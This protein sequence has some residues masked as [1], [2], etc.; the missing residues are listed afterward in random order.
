MNFLKFL[1]PFFFSATA[2][3]QAGVSASYIRMT[4][5]SLPSTCRAGDIRVDTSYIIQ[6]CGNTNNW[7]PTF[8]L[9]SQTANTVLAGPTSGGSATPT[10]RALV[11]ADLPSSIPD[12]KL[13]TISTA[14]K[15]AN[16]ATT[17]TSSNTPSTIVLRDGSGNFAAGT[18]TADLNGNAT[19]STSTTTI[20][21]TDDTST[22]ATMF[23]TWVTA[24]TG[25]LPNKVS[26]TKLTF[27]PSIPSVGI[28]VAP[29]TDVLL[30]MDASTTSATQRIVFSGHGVNN[31][32]IRFKDSRG[33]VGSPTATQTDDILGFISGMPYGT[34]GYTAASTIAFNMLAEANVSDTSG[35]SY[36][37][38]MTSPTNSV[39]AVEVMRLNSTGNLAIG[40]TS[41]TIAR[42]GLAGNQSGT[43]SSTLGNMF[44]AAAATFTDSNTAGSG[45]AGAYNA[46][47]I[48]APT[49][50][51]TNSTVTT[52]S[53]ATLKINGAV[54]AGTNET[55]T[56][57]YGLWVGTVS[58][59]S[60]AAAATAVRVQA[61][62]GATNN[63]SG[64]F[65][66][67]N[68]GVGSTS[69]TALLNLDGNTSGTPSN[70]SG[71]YFAVGNNTF[72][73]SNTAGAGTATGYAH[74][75]TGVQTLAAT[76]STVTT[77]SAQ[78]IYVNSPIVAGTN[79]TITNSYG[80]R[81]AS[82]NV[83]SG[84]TN[85]Y[86]LSVAASSGATNNYG[87]TFTGRVG[88]GGVTDPT[89]NLTIANSAAVVGTDEQVSLRSNSEAITSGELIG[90]IQFRS[91]DTNLSTPTTVAIIDAV[92][93][94]THTASV[95]DTGIAFHTTSTLT[96]NEKMR[97]TAA[98]NVGIGNTAPTRLLQVGTDA[99]KAGV[100]G[101][102]NGSG[103]GQSV[104]IQNLGTTSA[105]NFNLPTSAGSVGQVLTSQGG[106]SNSMTWASAPS[107]QSAYAPPTVQKFTS[108]SGTY[109]LDYTFVITSGSATVGATYTN[110]S[111]T[112]TVYATVA[113]AT[114]VVMSGSGAP[115]SSGTLTKAS[116][117]G[118]AT[119]T[120]SQVLTP[121]YLE[122][123][124][125]GAGGGGCG[126]GTASAGSGTN[127]GNTTFGSSLVTANGGSGAVTN[128]NGAAGG[129]ASLGTGALGNALT[130]GFGQSPNLQGLSS[131]NTS[132]A[133][134]GSSAFGGAGNGNYSA[135]AG[136][137]ITNTGG[138]G[139][140]GGCGS[141]VNCITGGGGGA[142]G[143]AK[144]IIAPVSA[145]YSYAVGASGAGGTAG[146][147]GSAGSA[148][149]SGIIIVHEHYQ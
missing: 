124:A 139:G 45:T 14:G 42:L 28:G 95:L 101:I 6:S 18:I 17:A 103:S 10:F 113:S 3:G 130:G 1:I 58:V 72:T 46:N 8:S 144:A 120:F 80:I 91:N 134:G 13:A 112:F 143:Y 111:V 75:S 145:T 62:S 43:P 102:S 135:A 11:I 128:T 110:N 7:S 86:G 83:T 35:A 15:V 137:G 108:G 71:R 122:V 115:S 90:G 106:G 104:A 73:D 36:F 44:T 125:V 67:G 57:S 142:G 85:S 59:G 140:G 117:T 92:A 77:T 32:G 47:Y 78:T 109:N 19:T 61:P 31:Q 60:G 88:L 97:I 76:N 25:N 30:N 119:L 2:F 116:G 68:F 132:G 129:S 64:I 121:I 126:S 40:T 98:G 146:T 87:A 52:S 49:L 23:P 147:A 123:E 133:S 136:A 127:G 100:I 16:S 63:Y 70:A 9:T 29:A 53:A 89:Q 34:T 93:E 22:N 5:T 114:Q 79:E 37:Q 96:T 149:G 66:G 4:P 74:M 54:I 39:T 20:G 148:S 24:S 84:V 82:N 131:S 56:N 21:I 27:N 94:A 107:A 118:D 12:S 51:A 141:T 105:W 138:G 65:T 38:W 69:P 33:T 41:S 50:A 55:L 26:S 48:G 81:I 99:S